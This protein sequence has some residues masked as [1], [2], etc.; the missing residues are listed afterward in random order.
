MDIRKQD[1]RKNQILDAAMEVITRHGY[2]NS[3][4]D[5]VVKS[6]KMS[7]GAIYWY[8][9][10]KKDIY[11]D[12]VNYWVLRYS[13]MVSKIL[14]KDQKASL[15]LKKIFSYFIDEYEKD[16]EPFKALTEFW[17]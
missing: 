12:L 17:S 11:L 1:L 9:N 16:P 2:E 13:D 7:K 14:E 15:Q 6:S 3:R 4:M 5:D 8:Y 10:S